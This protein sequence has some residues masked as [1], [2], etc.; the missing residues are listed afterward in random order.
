MSLKFCEI[1]KLNGFDEGKSL[2]AKVWLQNWMV[3]S[4][5]AI[6]EDPVKT[7]QAKGI[8]ARFVVVEIGSAW[9][10]PYV[11]TCRFLSDIK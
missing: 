7:K 1:A 2:A 6:A 8:L 11:L 9:S 5:S 4:A 3:Q 10:A